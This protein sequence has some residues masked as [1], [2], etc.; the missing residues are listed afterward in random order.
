[1]AGMT[2]RAG[3]AL[4]VT[5]GA[6]AVAAQPVLAAGVAPTVKSLT[7]SPAE[8]SA[9][10]GAVVLAARVTGA[11]T[12]TFLR[13]S[14]ALRTVACSSGRAS[15]TVSI[16]QNLSNASRTFLYSIRA[17]GS[18]KSAARSASVLQDGVPIPPVTI[19]GSP[20]QGGTVGVAYTATL[21]AS[22]GTPSYTWSV[23]SGAL[24]AGLTL[25]AAGTIS[26]TPTAAGQSTFT[27][28]ASDSTPT[29]KTATAQFSIAVL[30]PPLI[31]SRT[32]FPQGT[33][34]VFYSTTMEAAGGTPPYT[35]SIASGSVPG[36]TLSSSGVLRGT[37]TSAGLAS[38]TVRVTDSTGQTASTQ[39][40]INV[41]APFVPA[42]TTDTS[43]NWS[44]YVASGSGFTAVSSTFNVPTAAASSPASDAA[45]WVGIDGANNS[46]LIQ[47][48]VAEES[49]GTYAWW[50]ILPA[51]E[52]PISRLL[53]NPSAGDQMTV[54]ISQQ[55]VGVW[56]IRVSDDTKG[57]VFSIVQSYAGEQT[58]AEWIVEA[59]TDLTSGNILR[60]APYSPNVTFTNPRYTGN[61]T[62]IEGIQMIQGGV[63]V[64]TPSTI[65]SNGFT[66]AYGSSAPSPP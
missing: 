9:S 46:N 61:E 26:G 1:M 5:F 39:L 34:G 64:S 36:L 3:L 55:S 65:S 56:L 13:A 33:V 52:T 8:V 54:S 49:S 25:S 37:P 38:F 40:T 28:Q 48:G 35:W 12:C 43:S 15:T 27:V 21:T 59:A 17:V 7:A 14:T 50:E 29:V 30:P 23:V 53:V 58:S 6:G 24:P 19:A 2:L 57:Q 42:P 63:A 47:A 51:P 45:E 66:V 41:V 22:G 20:L 32:T 18:G 16:P 10:G 62:S 11:K 4:A 60:L 44:G 31:V